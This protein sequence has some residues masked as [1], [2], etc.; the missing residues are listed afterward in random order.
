MN[1]NYPQSSKLD[2]F[3]D[4]ADKVSDLNIDSSELGVP[5]LVAAP[6]P[7]L[8]GVSG[9]CVGIKVLIQLVKD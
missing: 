8:S 6:P 7:R 1:S 5:C 9:D 3:K 2:K 4:V